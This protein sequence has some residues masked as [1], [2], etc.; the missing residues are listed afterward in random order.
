LRGFSSQN[1]RWPVLSHA[2]SKNYAIN[3]H[4]LSVRYDR[5]YAI[6]D[7]NLQI[8]YGDFAGIIGPN[9]SGKSTLLKAMLGLV[10]PCSGE[11][12]ILG[13]SP[14]QARSHMAYV[15]QIARIDRYFPIS[16]Q[17]VILMGRMVGKRGLLHHYSDADQDLVQECM[18]QLEISDLAKRQIGQ[19][20]G[21][22]FRRVLIARALVVKPRLL[23][24]DEPTAG[25]DAHS[26]SQI[27]SILSELN[28]E[29][30]IILVT[31]DTMAISSYVKTIVCINHTLF[32]HGEPN[33][34]P[35]LIQKF[36]GCP[37]DLLAHGVPHRVLGHH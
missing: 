13:T 3:I 8:E 33:L 26:S 1:R 36:Y 15:P 32:Y 5:I 25:L 31:H 20:S 16:V 24:L 19:L 18:Q 22:Q 23:L 37:I 4:D 12:E 7:V 34:S 10:T 2:V 28:R 35:D 27:F 17:E 11:V 29:V 14:E 21:G 6:E 9:G 30:T